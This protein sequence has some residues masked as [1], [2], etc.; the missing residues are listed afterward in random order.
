M[1]MMLSKSKYTAGLQCV[2][3]LWLE[4]HKPGLKHYDDWQLARFEQGTD[5]GVQAQELFPGGVLISEDHRHIPEAMLSTRK[6]VKDGA[7]ILFE[8][9]A[10]FGRV[11][12]RADVLVNNGGK[13]DMVEVKSVTSIKEYQ[14][15]DMAIQ[16]WIFEGAGFKMGKSILCHIDREY[17]R[18]GDIEWPKFFKMTDIT[19]DVRRLMP[20]IAK[21]VQTFLEVADGKKAPD[22]PIGSRCDTPYGC[23][24]KD[25]CW[26]GMPEDNVFTLCG[27]SAVAERLY[28]EG[29]IRITDIPA[30]TKLGKNQRIQVEAAKTGKKIWKDAE[31]RNFVEKI[32]YPIQFL[33]F[34]A[35]NPRI[36]LYDGTF[37][38]QKIAFQYS[39]HIVEKPGAE[40]IHHEFLA[41]GKSDPRKALADSLAGVLRDKGSVVAYWA[42]YEKDVLDGLSVLFPEHGELFRSAIRR[43]QDLIIPFYRRH[44]VYPE[45]QGS[46]SLK[47]VLPAMIPG[48]TY[49]GME[50]GDGEAAVRA[51]QKMRDERTPKEEAEKIRKDLLAYCCQD[52]M[53]MVKLFEVLK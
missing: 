34:E 27:S 30:G 47:V 40:P 18:H 28:H 1:P 36:P 49:D 9:A 23:P 17:V 35:E 26:K 7:K 44:I 5:I 33:D 32:E 21:Q 42:A 2:K 25:H 15:Q 45:F 52:T 8:P 24:F 19:R 13:W 22:I 3:R 6:A 46:A 38:G 39:M 50:V 41:D 31:V 12:A 29:I 51:Y 14:F 20:G 16:R 37:S 4:V 11:M 53:A 10:E 48:M 43:M